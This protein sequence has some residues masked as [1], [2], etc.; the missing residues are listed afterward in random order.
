MRR[1]VIALSQGWGGTPGK[2]DVMVDG[3]CV[4]ALIDT[5]THYENINAM[6]HMSSVP[7]RFEA[8]APGVAV[9]A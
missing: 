9:L 5:A 8:V 1:G 2:E 3:T 6:P 4:N 7:V